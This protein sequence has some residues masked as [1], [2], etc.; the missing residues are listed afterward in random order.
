MR[1]GSSER[2]GPGERAWQGQSHTCSSGKGCGEMRVGIVSWERRGL[3]GRA[4]TYERGTIR[5]K[6]GGV[7]HSQVAAVSLDALGGAEAL[8]VA[9]VAHGGV[10]VTL[11]G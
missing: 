7:S 2:A 6:W 8:A 1:G 9:G 5:A 11:A 4:G 10:A 3:M